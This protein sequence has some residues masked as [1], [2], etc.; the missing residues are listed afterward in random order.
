MIYMET[1]SV[2]RAAQQSPDRSRELLPAVGVPRRPT[3]GLQDR[4]SGVEQR[5]GLFTQLW[6]SPGP[7]E[8]EDVFRASLIMA[9]SEEINRQGPAGMLQLLPLV[10]GRDRGEVEG[11]GGGVVGYVERPEGREERRRWTGTP[12]DTP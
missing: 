5:L 8:R 6:G 9:A 11:K 3:S 2:I 10:G 12:G 7:G 1:L 4:G